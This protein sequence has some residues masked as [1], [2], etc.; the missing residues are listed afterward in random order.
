MQQCEVS[1]IIVVAQNFPRR[2]GGSLYGPP[3]ARGALLRD[4]GWSFDSILTTVSFNTWFRN[5][6]VKKHSVLWLFLE[7]DL[8]WLCWNDEM[9]IV[10]F[11]QCS[12]LRKQI[13]CR[14]RE[15]TSKPQTQGIMLPLE[16]RKHMTMSARK[17][18]GAFD[19]IERWNVALFVVHA[20]LLTLRRLVG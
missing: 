19:D 14:W 4:P 7:P 9:R 2:S 6:K 11:W 16:L 8:I 1:F 20:R 10:Q 3:P 18:V 5:D 12:I 13:V 15:M 17:F